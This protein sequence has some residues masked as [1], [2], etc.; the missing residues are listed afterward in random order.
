MMDDTDRAII[1][2]LQDGF[3]VTPRPFA[4]AAASLGIEEDDLIERIGRLRADGVL[5]RFGPMYHA[6]KLGGGL[7][8]CAVAVPEDR[9]DEV[10]ESINAHPEVAH[11]YARAHRLNMWFVLAT[12][13]PERIAEVAGEI[14][15]ATGLHVLVMPKIE[16]FYV[17]LRFEA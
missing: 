7:A 9:F 2:T 10:T 8:L 3:P 14:E 1:N 11:N 12:E 5:S 4:A 6:E 15:T 13:R 16:E 17:G